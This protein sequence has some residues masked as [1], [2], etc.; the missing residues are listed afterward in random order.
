MMSLLIKK[1]IFEEDLA[2]FYTAELTLA[3]DSVHSMG[4]IHRDIKPDNILITKE[5]H[6]KLTDFGLCTGFRWTHSSNY[7][8]SDP[9][10]GKKEDSQGSSKADSPKIHKTQMPVSTSLEAMNRRRA[11]SLVGTPNYIA[12]EI[13]RRKDYDQSCDWWSVGVILYE[14]LVGQPPFLA[15]SAMDTQIRVVQW[16]KYLH[17][18][19]EPR[20]N[21]ASADMMRRFMRD[22]NE[23]LSNPDEIKAHPFF[24]GILPPNFG[25]LFFLHL[26]NENTSLIRNELDTSNFDAVEDDE[27]MEDLDEPTDLQMSTEGGR[28][29]HGMNGSGQSNSSQLPFPNFT[30][31]RFFDRD[32]SSINN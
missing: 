19:G 13:L 1:G 21:K 18:P 10:M 32:A 4:F 15:Q 25:Q 22:P 30:F 7:W 12:P 24:L 31:K 5:G 8:D 6:I 26:N 27:G 20:L 11:Q 2:R 3:L 14:M 23:R 28:Y 17:V 16:Q 9:A 29:K